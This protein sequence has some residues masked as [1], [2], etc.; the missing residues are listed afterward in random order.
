[1]DVGAPAAI[2]AQWRQL[3]ARHLLLYLRVRAAAF[4]WVLLTPDPSRCGLVFTGI[5]GPPEE[6]AQAGLEPRKSATDKAIADYALAFASTPPFSHAAYGLVGLIL[7]FVLL[8]RRRPPD[9][10]V[11]AMLASALAFT[12]SFAVISIACDYRY[13]YDLDLSVIAAALY[14]AAGSGRRYRSEANASDYRPLDL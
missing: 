13:L 10:A 12:A 1:M 2:A 14:V 8:R 7:L 4:R 6:M 5:D 9:I 3:I 11:A